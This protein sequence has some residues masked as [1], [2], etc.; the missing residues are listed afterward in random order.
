MM[1]IPDTLENERFAAH[2][3]VVNQPHIRFYIGIPLIL[4]DGNYVGTLSC[5]D[6]QP[7]IFT[8]I[9]L[10]LLHDLRDIVLAELYTQPRMLT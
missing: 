10:N 2:P 4:H 1:I 5:L 7:H 9:E 8:E 3:L 6:I